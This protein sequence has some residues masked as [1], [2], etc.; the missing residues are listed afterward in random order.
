MRNRASHARSVIVTLVIVSMAVIGVVVVP[1]SVTGW[2]AG[3]AT[4]VWG[5]S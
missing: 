3:P 2:A 1:P 5:K 4:F